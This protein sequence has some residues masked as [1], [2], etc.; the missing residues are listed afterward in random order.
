MLTRIYGRMLL[1]FH[2]RMLHGR[3]TFRYLAELEE[4]QWLTPSQIAARQLHSLRRLLKYASEKC[5]FFKEEWTSRGLDPTAL[6]RLDD[7]TRW[8]LLTR[9]EIHSHRFRLRT[10]DSK[11]TLLSKATGGSSGVPLQFDLNVESHER[12]EAAT[13]RGYGWASAGPGTRQF[14]LWGVPLGT[15]TRRQRMKDRLYNAVHRRSL[16]S[17]FSL[18]RDSI[19]QVLSSLNRCRPQAIVAYTS[20]LYSLAWELAE[21]KIVPFSPKTVIVGAEKLHPFQR[22]LIERVFQAPVFETYGSREVMLMGAE[23]DKHAGLHLSAENLL[24]EVIGDDG[25]PANDGEEGNVVVTDLTN[26]GMPFIRYVNGDRAIAGYR[27]CGCGRGLPLLRQVAGRQA[28]ILRTPSGRILTGLFFPHFLKDFPAIERYQV[29]QEAI[30]E[31]RL[32]VVLRRDRSSFDRS[33][34]RE[35]IASY[36]GSDVRLEVAEVDHI[37]LTSAG[38]HRVVVSKLPSAGNK[39]SR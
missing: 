15:R 24:V 9:E 2:E 4:S 34:V 39:I 32:D 7:F 14:F 12:R 11:M 1:P 10:T 20:A 28:D 23:C 29:T 27:T 25:R 19:P 21:T 37:P 31:V 35:G 33:L 18:S 22:E 17:S 3:R 6:T 36:L 38:K 26:F 16:V 30:D 13:Y 5:P 8:P